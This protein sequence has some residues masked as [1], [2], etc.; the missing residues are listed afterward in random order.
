MSAPRTTVPAA[1]LA[2]LAISAL[3]LLGFGAMVIAPATGWDGAAVAA[4]FAEAPRFSPDA[5][6]SVPSASDLRRRRSAPER[7]EA[8][9]SPF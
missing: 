5:A 9:T 8:P 7:D 2:L 3:A 1:W 6:T 4:S